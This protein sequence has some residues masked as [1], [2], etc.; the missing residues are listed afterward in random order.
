MNTVSS[1]ETQIMTEADGESKPPCDIRHQEGPLDETNVLA[2]EVR[3]RPT[4][5]VSFRLP[6]SQESDGFDND[7]NDNIGYQQQPSSQTKSSEEHPASIHRPAPTRF[8]RNAMTGATYNRRAVRRF[9]PSP[10][11]RAHHTPTLHDLT[12]SATQNLP[13]DNNNRPHHRR[14]SSFRAVERK[15][16]RGKA[17]GIRARIK[18]Y[19]RERAAYLSSV[20]GRD[21]NHL[22][23]MADQYYIPPPEA[24]ETSTVLDAIRQLFSGAMDDLSVWLYGAS[25]WKILVFSWMLYMIFVLF[26][27]FIIYFVDRIKLN[28]P[29]RSGGGCIHSA[30]EVGVLP[31]RVQLEFA[32]DLSWTTFTTVGYGTIAPPGD[33]VG[34][35]NIRVVCSIEAIL[36]MAFVSMCSG[37]FYARLT[38]LLGEAP[39]TFSSTLCVQYGKGLIDAG[40][41]YQPLTE[42]SYKNYVEQ[43]SQQQT[44][45]DEVLSP[46]PVLEFRVVNNR[47][48]CAHGQNDIFDAECT[49]MVQISLG[50]GLNI[51]VDD[52]ND[53]TMP[54]R[55]T[56]SHTSTS[57]DNNDQKVYYTL[58]FKPSF[59]PYFSRVWILQH[60]L[61]STSPLLKREVRKALHLRG[62]K[63][64]WDPAMNRYQDIRAALVEF[65]S[66]RVILSGSSALS[67]SDVYAEKVYSYHDICVGWQYVGVCYDVDNKDEYAVRS[68]CNNFLPCRRRSGTGLSE[69]RTRVDFSLIHDIVPQRGGD[70]EPLESDETLLPASLRISS[71]K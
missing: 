33:E 55:W 53:R 69:N 64:G 46:F 29:N 48:N 54:S 13:S 19:L 65:N 50:K 36:G 63:A 56:S 27:V 18:A 58:P 45:T 68:G 52:E 2:K 40:N 37:L 30:R 12:D 11:E 31:L 28:D 66:L 57:P 51:N 4:A 67:K 22:P 42:E 25:F 34:C 6:Q 60:K 20:G 32:F 26:F 3:P 44:G 61:D 8:R 17:G 59:H 35:Y 23:R 70:Y 41:R 43:K 49:V 62:K 39:V 47:A 21:R 71:L 10:E 38:R 1:A 16:D 24:G 14:T 9:P 15:G 5:T 7:S